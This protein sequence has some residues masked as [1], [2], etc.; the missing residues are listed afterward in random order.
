MRGLHTFRLDTDVDP[1]FKIIKVNGHVFAPKVWSDMNTLF[2]SRNWVGFDMVARHDPV[3]D[4]TYVDT[5]RTMYRFVRLHEEAVE[6]EEE[7]E[8]KDEGEDEDEDGD[9]DEDEDENG[10]GDGDGDRGEDKDGDEDEE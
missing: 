9:E 8:D 2:Q 7:E 1:E 3:P 6:E 5:L 10:D 4:S